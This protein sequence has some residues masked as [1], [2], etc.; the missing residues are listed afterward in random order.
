M[1]AIN[2]SRQSL[3]I[4]PSEPATPAAVKEELP[5]EIKIFG[6][7][8]TVPVKTV[9]NQNDAPVLPDVKTVA[10][11]AI[12]SI[13]SF[14]TMMDGELQKNRAATME[15]EVTRLTKKLEEL[16]NKRL[17]ALEKNR[18][19]A[20][21]VN[22]ENAKRRSSGGGLFGW[23]KKI[24]KIVFKA[25]FVAVAAAATVATGGMAA[26]LLAL[27]TLSL[28]SSVVDVASDIDKARG[29]KGFDHITQ[30]M[31]PGSAMGKGMGA[32]AKE[33]GA[34]DAQAAIVSTSFAIATTVAIAVATAVITAGTSASTVMQTVSNL[35]AMSTALT[36]I[37]DGAMAIA[38]G[39]VDREIAEINLEISKV[40]SDL[41]KLF[42][43]YMESSQKRDEW[44]EDLKNFLEGIQK[45]P[46]TVSQIVKDRGESD[47]QIIGN[48]A[49]TQTA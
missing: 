36:G 34:S 31:D 20:V 42:A 19:E 48:M 10:N 30:W 45:A 41:K 35:A 15:Q 33:L 39:I 47:S 9:K 1:D 6:I 38:D 5:R 11:L 14:I 22:E 4:H 13:S 17:D 37:I 40:E 8:I 32:L 49:S 25:V 2:P 46:K 3:P 24:V 18:A 27:A 16:K 26:P 21:R 44:M 23:L 28:A 29:G 43:D 12:D 7:K